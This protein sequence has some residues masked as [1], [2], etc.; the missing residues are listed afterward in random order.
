LIDTE[1][2]TRERSRMGLQRFSLHGRLGATVD[3]ERRGE[4]ETKNGDGED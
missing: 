2:A 1:L 4:R 3:E